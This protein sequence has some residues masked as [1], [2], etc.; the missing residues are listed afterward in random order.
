MLRFVVYEYCDVN[1]LVTIIFIGIDTIYRKAVSARGFPFKFCC[2]H[3]H[4]VYVC[5][6]FC[7]IMSHITRKHV[8][9][10]NDKGED[11]P[12]HQRSLITNFVVRFLIVCG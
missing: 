5:L 3:G 9:L 11:Q 12:A 1:R 10:S 2:L 6:Y 7:Y 4:A 8:F